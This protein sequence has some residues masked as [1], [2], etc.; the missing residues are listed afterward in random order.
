MFMCFTVVSYRQY[1]LW[2]VF[3]ACIA[4]ALLSSI[5]SIS[6]VPDVMDYGNHIAAIIQ[7]KIALTEGQFPLRI[8]P[9]EQD[10]WRYPF[11]QFYSPTSYLLSGFIY[12]WLTPTNPFIAYQFTLWCALIIGG[13]Y[14]NRL[15]YWFVPSRSAAML[16]SVVYL[17]AP[18]NTIVINQIGGFN[19]AIALGILPAVLYYTLQ[20]FYHSAES[21]TFLQAGLVW[22]CLATIH[23]ITFIY[24]S[25]FVAIFLILIASQSREYW[26]NLVRF[27]IAYIYACCLAMWYLAPAALFSKYLI[28]SRTFNGNHI[29][30]LYHASIVSL[31]SPVR[32]ISAA[33]KHTAM[34][35]IISQIHPNMGLPILLAVGICSYAGL[36]QRPFIDRRSIHWFVALWIL[37]FIVV[38]TI[39]SPVNFWKWLPPSVSMLQYSWRLLGQIMWIGALLF[40]WAIGWLCHN[41]LDVWHVVLGVFLIIVSTNSWYP[42]AQKESHDIADIVAH[43][44][45]VTNSHVYLFDFVKYPTD[46]HAVNNGSLDSSRTLD[47]KQVRVGCQQKN[48]D[49]VCKI[50]VAT[51]IQV[52]ELPILYYPNLLNITVNGK[53]VSYKSAHYQNRLIAAIVPEPGKMNVIKINFRG[54]WWANLISETSWG[55]GLIFLIF[56]VL[57][58]LSTKK[59][60]IF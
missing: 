37:F 20:R 6:S 53:V 60:V 9:L 1:A 3:Y 22:Y 40:A 42:A 38:V 46:V 28:V 49:T 10:G 34:I 4:A 55:I 54:L 39:A 52:L 5:A 43:P 29:S 33:G 59:K 50:N 51:T 30:T 47:V 31:L 18:Y 7:A 32:N 13:M 57:Q 8:A 26:R 27:A 15:A 17:T 11:F 58:I 12:K 23:I 21:K 16:A 24:T 2:F 41:K 44:Y 36:I 45:L 48:E 19:E 14:M 56:L 35:D 25:F